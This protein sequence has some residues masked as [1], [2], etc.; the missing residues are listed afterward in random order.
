M[1]EKGE[2]REKEIKEEGWEEMRRKTE[3]RKKNKKEEGE[4]EEERRSWARKRR[5]WSLYGNECVYYVI[6]SQRFE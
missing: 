1:G 3:R 6:L 4:E 5:F 2:G